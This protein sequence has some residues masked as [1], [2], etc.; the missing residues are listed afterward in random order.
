[1]PACAGLHVDRDA[2]GG[3]DE[4]RRVLPL[5]MMV[6]L[7]PMPLNSLKV[8]FEPAL[9]LVPVKAG[10]VEA[11]REVRAADG[12]DRE[13]RIGAD[14]AVAGHGARGQVDRD[15]EVVAGSRA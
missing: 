9:M 14:R 5:P 2:A 11:V 10:R 15:A 7:P 13:Q 4:R 8:P 6:S 1:M 12:L 3:V